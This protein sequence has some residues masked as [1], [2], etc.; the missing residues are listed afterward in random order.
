MEKQ[1]IELCPFC[2]YECEVTAYKF[3]SRRNYVSCYNE[4]TCSYSGPER[5]TEAEA[6]SAHNTVARNNAAAGKL[7]RTKD[8]V[9]VT[10]RMAVFCPNGHECGVVDLGNS[11]AMCIEEKCRVA[12]MEEGFE[13]SDWSSYSLSECFSTQAKAKASPQEHTHDND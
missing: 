10:P 4:L 12:H 9:L 13:V 7:D 3:G 6:I 8:G 11:I 1:T 2:G 5:E